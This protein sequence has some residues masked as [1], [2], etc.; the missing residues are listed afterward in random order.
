MNYK[1]NDGNY[2]RLSEDLTG[3][4]VNLLVLLPEKVREVEAKT[5]LCLAFSKDDSTLV[6][7]AKNTDVINNDDKRTRIKIG[8]FIRKHLGMNEDAISDA[9]IASIAQQASLLVNKGYKILTGDALIEEYATHKDWP[10]RESTGHT[11]LIGLKKN[12]QVL[13]KYLSQWVNSND[14]NLR[15]LVSESTRPL[16]QVKWLRDPEK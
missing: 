16:T 2:V 9:E 14:E 4:R 8:R 6:S 1:L 12:P 5:D 13:L 11:I 3:R 15:R 10:V 7:Y